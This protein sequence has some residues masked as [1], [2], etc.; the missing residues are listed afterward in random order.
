MNSVILNVDGMSC[1][2]CKECIKNS[3]EKLNGVKEVFVDLKGKTV[4]L[5]FENILLDEI[6]QTIEEQGYDVI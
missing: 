6:K 2:H 3:L 5:K 4:S 1:S